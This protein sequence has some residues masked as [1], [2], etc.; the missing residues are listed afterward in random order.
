MSFPPTLVINLNKD[1]ERMKTI[2]EDFKAIGWPVPLERVEAVERKPGYIGC[3]LSHMKCME[4]ALEHG[5]DWV[6]ILEDDCQ[7]KPNAKQHFTAL[8]PEL[9]KRRSEWDNYFAGPLFINDNPVIVNKRLGLF[10]VGGDCTH[11]VLVHKE[12]CKNILNKLASLEK[13]PIIDL[14]YKTEIRTF[15][16]VPYIAIQRPGISNIQGNNNGKYE[17]HTET[18]NKTEQKLLALL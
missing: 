13:I 4:L 12:G 17:D 16:S 15:T 6:L 14:F 9:W 18:F 2:T 1:K 7:V 5:Y 8:L 3:T 11:F 10:N